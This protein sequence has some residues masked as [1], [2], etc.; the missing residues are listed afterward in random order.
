MPH[1]AQ[2]VYDA[3]FADAQPTPENAFK[4]VLAK[5]TLASVLTQARAG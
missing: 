3:L 5:R 2:A 1:G 4:L